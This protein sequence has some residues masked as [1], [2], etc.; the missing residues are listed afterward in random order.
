LQTDE[1]GETWQ[2]GVSHLQKHLRHTAG[3]YSLLSAL[4]QAA[5]AHPHAQICWFESHLNCARRYF[6]HGAWHNFRPDAT[7]LYEQGDGE[8]SQ[9][10]LLWL[11]WD[12]ATMSREQLRDKMQSYAYYLRSREWRRF[13]HVTGLPVLLFV[14]PSAGQADTLRALAEEILAE[15]QIQVYVTLRDLLEERGMFAPIWH[16][17]VPVTVLKQRNVLKKPG[18]LSD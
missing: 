13:G 11:E 5:R 7:V 8:H 1:Q 9:R 3:V 15:T 14:T 4:H 10:W 2:T 6:Y 12:G 18:F 17:A 16:Q